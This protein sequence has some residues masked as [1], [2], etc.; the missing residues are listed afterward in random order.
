MRESQANLILISAPPGFGKTT[1]ASMYADNL[2]H[3]YAWLS[4]DSQDDVIGTFVAYL[5]AAIESAVPGFGQNILRHLDVDTSLTPLRL[6]DLFLQDLVDVGDRLVLFV[7][8]FH[9]ITSLEIH[10]FMARVIGWLPQAVQ[11]VIITRSD[12]PLPVSRLR[13]RRQITEIRSKQ[14]RFSAAEG[15]TFVQSVAGS[16][17]EEESIST[18]VQQ[19][20]GWPAAL[21]I[22]SMAIKDNEDKGKPAAALIRSSQH[23]VADYLLDEVMVDLSQPVRT[24]L[25]RAALFDRFSAGLLQAVSVEFAPDLDCHT[26]LD[27]LWQSNLFVARLDETGEWYRFHALF[28]DF[29]AQRLRRQDGAGAIDRTYM[30]AGEWFEA[31]GLI[32][33]AVTCALQSSEPQRAA[34]IVERHA[35]ELVNVS[36][37][38]RLQAWLDLLPEP[39]HVR[40]GIM[41]PSAY[42]AHARQ[43][44]EKSHALLETAMS[45]LNDAGPQYS[46]DE[47]AEFRGQIMALE[48]LFLSWFAAPERAIQHA[49]AA[50]Q[51]LPPRYSSARSFAEMSIFHARAKR[52]PHEQ[53]AAAIRL[54]IRREATLGITVRALR[55]QL[56]L[57][58]LLYADEQVDSFCMEIERLGDMAGANPTPFF[59]GWVHFGLG[60]VY[61]QRND[62]DR[63]ERHFSEVWE[64]H[65]SC[66]ARAVI[67][68]LTGLVYIYQATGRC[69]HATS[70]VHRLSAFVRQVGS[71][72]GH[73]IAD[74][75]AWRL[76]HG[77]DGAVPPEHFATDPKLQMT[78]QH[79]EIPACTAIRAHIANGSP[80][81]IQTAAQLLTTLR[82][83]A[84]LDY[85]PRYA[86]MIG[87]LEVLLRYERGDESAAMEL[88]AETID[89][90]A[91]CGTVRKVADVSPQ[92]HPLLARLHMHGRSRQF[93]HKV[94]AASGM[95]A[96]ALEQ[97]VARSESRPAFLTDF[98]SADLLTPREV[99]VLLLLA[100]RLTDKEIAAKLVI[101][102][103]TVHKHTGNIFQKLN[104]QN[105]RQAVA[106]AQELGLLP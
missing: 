16:V 40:P 48:S 26:A 15:L 33:E 39:L 13:G 75:L 102:Q 86:T 27:E 18:L 92:L 7:D 62:L 53:V 101:S 46:R 82:E 59:Q 84:R 56:E 55:L 68:S 34:C 30:R 73:A 76:E 79:W 88:L 8:D 35:Y 54:A 25:A 95:A 100:R 32:E 2:P 98:R 66:H 67:D 1:L 91:R 24:M 17:V 44:L 36:D 21:G 97:E 105:R 87:L 28:R 49:T 83:L 31:A 61:Y 96:P 11:I 72:Q 74:S 12:P 103:R 45:A 51:A 22:L 41:V 60:W 104:V 14:L 58:S 106:T 6:A 85:Q 50:L 42:L 52:E 70:A 90:A 71:P 37:W 23:L 99:D 63:A 10:Q 20:E 64:I 4:L 78:T 69:R 57:C 19:S 94:F 65:E 38:Q 9:L 47:A 89:I 5:A 3:P 81:S 80:E 29:L 93:L 43:R 77:F